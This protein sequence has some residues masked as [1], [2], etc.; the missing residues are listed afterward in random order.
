MNIEQTILN[1]LNKLPLDKQQEVLDFV[2]FLTVRIDLLCPE[3]ANQT[4]RQSLEGAYADL[5][6]HLTQEDITA[7]RREMWGNGL[8]E[9]N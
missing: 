4:L 9:V 8:R 2:E 5:D 1:N 6:V 3:M 7:A